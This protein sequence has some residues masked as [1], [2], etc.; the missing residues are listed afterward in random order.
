MGSADLVPAIIATARDKTA[1]SDELHFAANCA[2]EDYHLN[3]GRANVLRALDIPADG[4]VLEVGAEYGALTRYL[5]ERAGTVDAVEPDPGVVAVRT[6]DLDN[7]R[8][9]TQLRDGDC[10]DYDLAVVAAHRAAPR[11][12]K[13]IRDTPAVVVAVDDL[14][15]RREVE[16]AL[17]SAEL[18]IAK[19]LTCLPDRVA[20]RAVVTEEL[21]IEQPRLAKAIGSAECPGYLVLA[22]EG[23]AKLWPP[24]RLASYFNTADRAAIWCTKAEVVRT[25]TGAEVRHTPLVPDPAPVDGIAVRACTDTVYDAP[26]ILSVLLEEPWRASELL[27]RWRDL[28]RERA[29]EVGPALWDLVPHNVLV[30][31]DTL[32]PIDLEWEH[33]GVGVPEVTERGL[34][35]LAHYL[36]EAGWDGA[37]DGST[38]REL[39][40]WLGVLVGL[41]P[42]YVDEAAAREVSFSTI[43]SC[44]SR[45]GTAAVHEA[46][47]TVWEERLAQPATGYRSAELGG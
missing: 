14:V 34:L 3:H 4:R 47:R 33:A 26:T 9:H 13:A 38:M 15:T 19:V 44:G 1:L 10:D 20:T 11:L 46:I 28:L 2:E 7:V 16:A 36:S 25:A 42:S 45:R 32:R 27:T 18:P 8:V 17:R 39:A 23:A 21:A 24:D 41:D 40:G 31:G 29:P 30:D 43:G 6:G 12:L 37:A 22:G 35:V 5:G